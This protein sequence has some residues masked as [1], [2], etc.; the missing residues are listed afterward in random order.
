MRALV[1]R[2]DL[3][4]QVAAGVI[5]K[6]DSS[7]YVSRLAPIG[8][9]KLPDP[10]VRGP[11]WAVLENRLCGICGS[12]SKQ[13]FLD[14]STDNPLTAVISFPQVL[15][16]EMVG[17]ISEAGEAVE[18]PPGTRVALYC[19]LGC[20]ARGLE[21]PC[22]W[23]AGGDPSLCERFTEGALSA[24]I[25]TGNCADLPGGFADLVPAHRSQLFP[26]PDDVPDERA[27]F[28]DPFSVA[29][30]A[31]LRHPPATDRP[32]L[33]YGAGTIGLCLVA[34]LRRAHPGLEVWVV[35]REAQQADAAR[36][37]GAAR[38]L[39]SEPRALIEEVARSTG[40]RLLRPWKGEPWVQSGVLTVYD[41]IASGETIEASL[42]LIEQR[43]RIVSV[44]VA[45]P[46][47]FE[48]SLLYFKEIALVGSN[49]FGW[50]D[51]RGERRH[52][53]EV[54]WQLCREGLDLSPLLTDRYP[55]DQWRGAFLRTRSHHL[56]PTIK[57][58]F[59]FRRAR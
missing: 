30:H 14:G 59:D 13:V 29:L 4:R 8:L 47:R 20:A 34:A 46:E 45:T 2:N 16:H 9:E 27:V 41:A 38:T 53:Y 25:H 17:R 56:H 58:A 10:R 42:R 7:A 22:R 57:V 55:L 23:C 37:L 28:A 19:N 18:I 26:I 31:V 40:A 49:A 15:G 54:Y 51:W 33:V 48:W 3:L 35:A 24:G 11:E 21:P 52:C 1:F 12:D 6:F 36:R 5:G 43:G 39:P 32:A 50:V 44:G